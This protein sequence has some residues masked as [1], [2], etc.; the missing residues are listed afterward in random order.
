MSEI[1]RNPDKAFGLANRRNELDS[2]NVPYDRLQPQ[3]TDLEESVL[4]AI[5][6]DKDA[7][8]VVLDILRSE[9]FYKPVHQKIYSAM[10]RLFETSKPIDILTVTEELRKEKELETIGGVCLY[11]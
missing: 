11:P 4:G 5:M 2:S 8:P 3:A 10:L 7:L 6:L 1:V 9:S